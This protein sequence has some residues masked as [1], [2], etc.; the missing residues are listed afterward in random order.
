[1]KPKIAAL[2]TASGGIGSHFVLHKLQGHEA[3]AAL[4]ESSFRSQGGTTKGDLK[5]YLAQPEN[6]PSGQL[7]SEQL[8]PKKNLDSKVKWLVL[9]KP[10]LKAVNYHRTFHPEIPVLYIFRNPVSFY[11]TWIRK[12]KEYGER[13]YGRTLTDEQV[14]SWFKSAFMSSL[15][16]LAQN[17][18]PKRDNIISFEHFHLIL[19]LKVEV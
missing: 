7:Y 8:L 2:I 1:M 3:I 13:R 6:F 16:E 19:L 5:R 4:K 15:F 12:W 17:F 11:Y 18:D 14:F 9:N 10:P